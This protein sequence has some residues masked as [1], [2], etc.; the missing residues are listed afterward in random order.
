MEQ[1]LSNVLHFCMVRSE[2]ASATW[3]VKESSPRDHQMDPFGHSSWPRIWW[4]ND[5]RPE[6]KG[7][8]DV[9]AISNLWNIRKVAAV[10]KNCFRRMIDKRK[11]ENDFF[12]KRRLIVTN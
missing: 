4:F 8:F 2:A 5:E 6:L 1:L 9:L 12:V 10:E 3:L 11:R 7:P